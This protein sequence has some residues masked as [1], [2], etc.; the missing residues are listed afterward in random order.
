VASRAYLLG[1]DLFNYGYYWEAHEVWEGLWKAC[2]RR[3]L[4]A[5]FLKGLIKLAAAGVKA[6]EGRLQGVVRH[7]ARA[8]ALFRTVRSQIPSQNYLGLN[9]EW[10]IAMAIDLPRHVT[11]VVG[12]RTVE[13]VF[14]F[15]LMPDSARG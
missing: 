10:L 9:V 2:G 8:E 1:C 13:V 3:G 7:A 14:D 6:R 11:P 12:G 4:T 5:D 15:N